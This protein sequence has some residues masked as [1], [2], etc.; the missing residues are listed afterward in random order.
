MEL[1]KL[2]LPIL[3]PKIKRLEN[4]IQIFDNVR[5]KYVLLTDEEWVRQSFINYLNNAKNYPLG[6]MKIEHSINYNSLKHRA[7]IVIYN[8]NLSIN[9]LVECKSPKVKITQEAFNQISR[10]NYDL[11]ANFLVVTNGIQHFCCKVDYHK[12][13][14][15]F[16]KEI[17]NYNLKNN[18][19]QS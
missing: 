3:I 18:Y 19:E 9:I 2:N 10:Y 11:K 12:R 16:L 15:N 13:K 4:R 14:I 5:N 7:D 6:L 8:T 17:P 1:P